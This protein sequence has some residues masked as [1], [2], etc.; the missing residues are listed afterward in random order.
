MALLH[1]FYCTFQKLNNKDPDQT[2]GMCRLI[3]TSVLH[4]KQD[5]VFLYE[6]HMIFNDHDMMEVMCHTDQV[7]NTLLFFRKRNFPISLKEHMLKYS[8]EA[9]H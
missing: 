6:A 8:L 9:S 5:Q 1:R 3:C 4:M 7:E 2:V